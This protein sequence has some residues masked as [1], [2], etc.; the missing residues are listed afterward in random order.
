MK[1]GGRK[2][3]TTPLKSP[4]HYDS[5]GHFHFPD[6]MWTTDFEWPFKTPPT[7]DHLRAQGIDTDSWHLLALNESPLVPSQDVSVA[8]AK[9]IPHLNRYPDN[10]LGL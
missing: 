3:V 6:T 7:R 9:V 10:V 8:I 4:T 5:T 1:P 2:M